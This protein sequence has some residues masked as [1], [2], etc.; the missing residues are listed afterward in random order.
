MERSFAFP[1]V[2][3]IV[4]VPSFFFMEE[5]LASFSSKTVS[6][7]PIDERDFSQISSGNTL[8]IY[9]CP[10]L[11]NT[12]KGKNIYADGLLSINFDWDKNILTNKF[13]ELLTEK[14]H[15][16]FREERNSRYEFFRYI[17]LV[18]SS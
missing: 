9:F 11:S 17:Y 5:S 2:I 16:L 1:V 4:F 3:D 6:I 8:I 12:E 18:L 15:S 14:L 13:E 7:L 10:H